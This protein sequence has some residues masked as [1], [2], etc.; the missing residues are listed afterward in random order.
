MAYLSCPA[1]T[2]PAPAP[3][4]ARPA[5]R[6][7]RSLS[8]AAAASTSRRGHDPC[9]SGAAD[10][11]DSPAARSWRLS[12]GLRGF[13][14]GVE[15]MGEEMLGDLAPRGAPDLVVAGDVGERFLEG[16]D[17]IRLTHQVRM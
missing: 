9:R 4:R 7:A 2:I 13:R 12:H 17:A 1:E 10:I 15:I 14:E 11:S 16:R 6:R 3:R 8:Y 5:R